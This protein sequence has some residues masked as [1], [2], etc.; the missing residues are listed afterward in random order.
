[1]KKYNFIKDIIVF[2]NQI[3][4]MGFRINSEIR[5]FYKGVPTLIVITVMNGGI[6]FRDLVFSS[7]MMDREKVIHESISAKSYGDKTTPIDE[8]VV[9]FWTSSK[10]EKMKRLIEGNP[11]L[12][13][14]DIHDRGKTL[15][16]ATT[17]IQEKYFPSSIEHCVMI[18]RNPEEPSNVVPRFIGRSVHMPDFLVGMGLDYKGDYRF[19][20]YIGTVDPEGPLPSF[21]GLVD[22]TVGGYYYSPALEDC[23]TYKFDICEKCLKE[24]FN[25]FVIPVEERERSP[26]E[27]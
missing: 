23:T 6:N 4:D 27:A 22:T 2:P 14:D 17:I 10:Q 16:V 24:I 1:M 9:D 15:N 19:L 5:E 3:T 11:V 18:M 21:Y 7:G 8:V 13:V 12:I 20:P 25:S 26:W